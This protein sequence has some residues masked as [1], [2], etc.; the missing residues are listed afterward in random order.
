MASW[1]A[2][3][4]QVGHDPAGSPYRDV[5]R[6]AGPALFAGHLSGDRGRVGVGPSNALS[7]GVRYEL[8]AGRSM[9]VQ[10]N[11][12]YVKGDRFIVDPAADSMAPARRTGPVDTELL[13]TEIALQLRLTGGKTWHGL[14]PYLGTGLG[15]AFDLRSPGD[16]TGSGYQ[17]GTKFTLSGAAGV[18][19]HPI[20]HVTVIADARAVMWRLKYPDTFKSEAP[21]GS[22]VLALTEK[23]TDWTLHPWISLGVG[24]TF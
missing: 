13:L 12:A 7:F 20:R 19:W 5:A 17:F 15:L 3:S 14:A 4:A 16:S 11:A 6:G 18:R 2:L 24:W 22:R 10:F 21:D 9:L 8:P 23:Q 1:R